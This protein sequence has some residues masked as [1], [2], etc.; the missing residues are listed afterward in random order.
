MVVRE[1][2]LVCSSLRSLSLE[3]KEG[4]ILGSKTGQWNLADLF[5]RGHLSGDPISNGLF[6]KCGI[7]VGVLGSCA[8]DGVTLCEQSQSVR[9]MRV[10]WTS[11]YCMP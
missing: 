11:T 3:R 5:E 10:I 9:L 1:E 8:D 4:F 6:G 7:A 2:E